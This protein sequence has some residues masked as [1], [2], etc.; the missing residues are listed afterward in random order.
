MDIPEVPIVI[1]IP[2]RNDS[3]WIPRNLSSVAIQKYQNYRVIYIDDCSTDNTPK[4]VDRTVKKLGLSNR[5]YYLR[6]PQRNYQACSRFLAY[7]LCHDSEVICMLDGDDW[8]ADD[9]VLLKV[10]LTYQK[11]AM[12]TYGSYRYFSNGK[13]ENFIYARGPAETFPPDVLY[14][15]SFRQYRWVSQHL[16]TAYAGLFKRIAI[17]DL[18]DS[19]NQFYRCC[20]DLAEM[21]P[22]LEMASPRIFQINSCLY[23][24]NIEASKRSSYS[25]FQRQQN[26]EQNKYRSSIGTRIKR[27]PKYPQVTL[28]NL[29]QNQNLEATY[30]FIDSDTV[31]GSH[32]GQTDF[33]VS[34][35]REQWAP[36]EIQLMVRIL[37][38]CQLP[39]LLYH[40]EVSNPRQLYT[41]NIKMGFLSDTCQSTKYIVSDSISNQN[42]PGSLELLLG[43]RCL[44][45]NDEAYQGLSKI[46]SDGT[47]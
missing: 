2:A 25:Y 4:L 19:D 3:D 5:F 32:N 34:G 6:T 17:E 28:N 47:I 24:Y 44:V 21:F 1:V 14:H 35:G 15:R 46:F 18:V 42:N 12:A 27:F 26:Q 10:S 29:Q 41:K 13:T 43:K 7:H 45:V 22:V 20:T 31:K 30:H 39:L 40:G 36:D 38:A 33:W 11:G 8:L 37:D 23:I 9:Q 16:R